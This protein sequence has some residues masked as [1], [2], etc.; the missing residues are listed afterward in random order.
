VLPLYW[1]W[2]TLSTLQTDIIDIM[3]S[4]TDKIATSDT[5]KIATNTPI[6]LNN[7]T[8][9]SSFIHIPLLVLQTQGS[10]QPACPL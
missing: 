2:Q 9:K 10:F 4:D 8:T 7:E 5:D 3:I 1:N 6:L